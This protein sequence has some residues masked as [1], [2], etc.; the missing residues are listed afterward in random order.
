MAKFLSTTI[1][2]VLSLFILAAPVSAQ[3][4]EESYTLKVLGTGLMLADCAQTYNMM[5]K[6]HIYYEMNPLLGQHPSPQKIL[7]VCAGTIA[8]AHIVD[9]FLGP[10]WSNTGWAVIIGLELHAVYNNIGV[11]E[12]GRE[13]ERSMGLGMSV[14]Q[15]ETSRFS[16]S[17]PFDQ[18]GAM[19]QLNVKF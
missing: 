13:I 1:A 17:V 3:E 5:K 12:D 7:W 9:H 19:L 11:I 14:Y 10:E 8:T 6:P 16:V 15:T 2:F 18:P 4:F